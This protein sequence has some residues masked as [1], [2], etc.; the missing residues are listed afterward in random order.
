MLNQSR[1]AKKTK[2][3]SERTHQDK[4]KTEHKKEKVKEE[5]NSNHVNDVK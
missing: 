4:E 1:I 5:Q 2:S 3:Q